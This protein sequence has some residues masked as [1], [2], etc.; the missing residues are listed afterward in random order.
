VIKLA[1]VGYGYWGPNIIRNVID[2]PELELWGLC[3]MNAERVA[4]FSAR[5]PG[6][7]T[8]DDL[9]EVLADPTVDAV[10]IATPP[11]T[12]YPLVKRALEANRHVLVEKP[13]IRVGRRISCRIAEN[14]P[15]GAVSA[16]EPL[17]AT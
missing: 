3:E 13:L 5:Y 1:V 6:V 14:R 9:D 2:R 15:A 10:S 17:Q 16:T 11:A 4:K 12:H 7:R 8:T